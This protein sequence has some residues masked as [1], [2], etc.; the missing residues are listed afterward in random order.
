MNLIG[1]HE[2]FKK[3]EGKIEFFACRRL[4]ILLILFFSHIVLCV[5]DHG[6]KYIA[7]CGMQPKMF[8]KHCPEVGF[9]ALRRQ[10]CLN[11]DNKVL[12]RCLF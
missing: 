4:S 3:I 2:P 11:L 10:Y 8:E 7:Y 9:T 12:L 1:N 6:I 5:S